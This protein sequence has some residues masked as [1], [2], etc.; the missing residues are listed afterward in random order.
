MI[1]TKCSATTRE[2]FRRFE[3]SM[4]TSTDALPVRFRDNF[5]TSVALLADCECSMSFNNL[6][7]EIS[8]SIAAGTQITEKE[9]EIWTDQILRHK[10]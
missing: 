7:S 5:L 9:A 2:T 3:T 8:R 6:R 10:P 1:A 4:L